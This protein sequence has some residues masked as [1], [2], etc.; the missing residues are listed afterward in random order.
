VADEAPQIGAADR[1]CALRARCAKALDRV[2]HLEKNPDLE[3]RWRAALT[4]MLDV[5]DEMLGSVAE[6]A[7]T[8]YLKLTPRRLQ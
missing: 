1:V 6:A 8:P 3:A 5:L 7:K 4:D 2:P